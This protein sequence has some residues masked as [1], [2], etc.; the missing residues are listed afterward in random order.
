M[1]EINAESRKIREAITRTLL[2]GI[3]FSFQVTFLAD[4]TKAEGD[5]LETLPFLLLPIDNFLPNLEEA[6]T[7]TVDN[8][9]SGNLFPGGQEKRGY[10]DGLRDYS[11]TA[12][13]KTLFDLYLK[14]FDNLEQLQKRMRDGG[15]GII[16]N[17][18]RM[19]KPIKRF[20]P[21]FVGAIEYQ[22]GMTAFGLYQLTHR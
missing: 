16:A 9:L 12:E 19:E 17:K 21:A 8:A 14:R 20:S 10:C 22:T 5:N 13:F 1:T 6:I 15:L 11:Q 18:L 4:D 7:L 2:P 3:P